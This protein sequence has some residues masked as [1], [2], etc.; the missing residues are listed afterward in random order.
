MTTTTIG[1]RIR[2][3]RTE[4]GWSQGHLA[5]Q[6]SWTGANG[7]RR[8]SKYEADEREIGYPELRTIA[9]ALGCTVDELGTGEPGGVL[10]QRI[11]LDDIRPDPDQP[12]RINLATEEAAQG[13][14]QLADSI[15]QH[16]VLQPVTVR[17][18]PYGG[19]TVIYGERRCR[20]AAEA[21]LRDIPAIVRTDITD[22]TDRLA[23][24]ILE[25]LQRLDLTLPELITGISQL[26]RTRTH[27]EI[28]TELGRSRPWV[29]RRAALHDASPDV[30]QAIADGLISDIDMAHAFEQLFD[31]HPQSAASNLAYMRKIA[32]GD[33]DA[34]QLTRA[35]IQS[36]VREMRITQAA[37]EQMQN[38]RHARDERTAAETQHHEQER[39][40][41][42]SGGYDGPV[43]DTTTG[44]AEV[45]GHEGTHPAQRETADAASRADEGGRGAEQLQAVARNAERQLMDHLADIH[46]A[47]GVRFDGIDC[48][49][50]ISL[51]LTKRNELESL[52]EHIRSWRPP[53]SGDLLTQSAASTERNASDGDITDPLYDQAEQIVCRVKNASISH[54][55]RALGTDYNRAAHLMDQL[56]NNG[57]VSAPY[58]DGSRRV[59]TATA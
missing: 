12:R 19:Y 27:D 13:I 22:D 26:A 54:L 14:R 35:D 17:P 5:D 8:I 18:A 52:V 44:P 50:N 42:T 28:A 48:T 3:K 11:P 15:R 36:L 49:W 33:I 32:A 1:A 38:E 53:A 40:N 47:A 39:A 55:Q 6:C 59:L 43:D 25:N 37:A 46:G 9:Q 58:N 30:W 34:P 23:I 45:T 10:V 16:D 20:A 31:L 4:R 29:S 24:Q 57:I 41:D 21:G 56:Q 7:A 51:A 2:D